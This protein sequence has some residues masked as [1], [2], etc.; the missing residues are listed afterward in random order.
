[1]KEVQGV[2]LYTTQEI[3]EM[4]GCTTVTVSRLR[5]SGKLR[6]TQIGKLC[7]SSEEAIKDYL[8]GIINNRGVK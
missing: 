3:A 7:Y 8:N 6:Y 1:M 5:K 2:K 4:L